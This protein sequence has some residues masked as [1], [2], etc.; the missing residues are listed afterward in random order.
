MLRAVAGGVQDAQRVES[1]TEL[2][3]FADT[4][5]LRDGARKSQDLEMF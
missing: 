4:W 3:I 1:A 5:L 2:H